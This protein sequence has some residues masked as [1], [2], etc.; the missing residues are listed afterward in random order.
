[1]KIYSRSI[2]AGETFC[3]SIRNA[4]DVFE[5]TEVKL[6]FGEFKRKYDPYKNE[7]GFGYYKRNIHGQVVATMILEPGVNC[8]LLSF[9]VVKSSS[10]SN[11]TKNDFENNVLYRIREIYDQFCIS[12]A[13]KQRVTIIWVE[14]LDDKFHVHQF[15]YK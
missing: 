3:T 4:K 11:S 1:M 15:V 8:P 14:L 9:Y 6:C 10:I 5:N 2:N 12:D 7:I 13:L